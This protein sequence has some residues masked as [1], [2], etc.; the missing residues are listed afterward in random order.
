MQGARAGTSPCGSRSHAERS[1]PGAYVRSQAALR[2]RC[3]PDTTVS[4]QHAG[5]DRRGRSRRLV[6][7]FCNPGAARAATRIV[8]DLVCFSRQEPSQD[9]VRSGGCLGLVA[10]CIRQ[11]RRSAC[12]KKCEPGGRANSNQLSGGSELSAM[13][14]LAC[15]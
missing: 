3:K 5:W 4:L 9:R 11:G 8:T 6:K 13:S 15:L 1:C 10:A 2:K 12:C 14:F 7:L